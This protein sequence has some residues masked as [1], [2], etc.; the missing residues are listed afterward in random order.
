MDSNDVLRLVQGFRHDLMNQLQIMQ[1]YATMGQSEKVQQKI[2]NLVQM[3]IEER[4]L[5]QLNTQVLRYG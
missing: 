2:D 5:F 3:Y 4:K 1:G